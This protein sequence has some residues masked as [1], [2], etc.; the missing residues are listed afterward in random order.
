MLNE[1]LDRHTQR[2]M[3]L[4]QQVGQL[5]GALNQQKYMA[6]LAGGAQA[7]AGAMA[8]SVLNSTNP[9]ASS[10]FQYRG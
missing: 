4:N 5:T 2:Q 6:G 9:Y 1:N 7:E 10:A 3:Q 8:R